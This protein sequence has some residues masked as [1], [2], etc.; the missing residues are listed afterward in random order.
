MVSGHDLKDLEELLKQT[1]NTKIK[2][3]TH[4]EMLPAH[5]YP[6]F[7]KYSHLIGN[8]GSSW[9]NQREEFEKFNGAILMTT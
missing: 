4:A 5:A 1:Q 8:Y 3:Y 2:I 6:L 7:K 9:S